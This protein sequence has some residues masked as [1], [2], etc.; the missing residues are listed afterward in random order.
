MKIDPN[1]KYIGVT[2]AIDL[3]FYMGLGRPSR[4]TITSWAKK[5]S[6]GI[7]VGGRW[8]IDERAFKDFLRHGR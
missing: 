5:Y 2:K 7:K 8:Y 1:K 4:P 3:T 6:L